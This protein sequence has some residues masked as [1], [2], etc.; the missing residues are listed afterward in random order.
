MRN[1]LATTYVLDGIKA[2]PLS[3]LPAA[4]WSPLDPDAPASADLRT[5]ARVVPILARAIDIRAKALSSLPFRVERDDGTDVTSDPLV[6]RLLEN[7]RLLLYRTE[8]GLCLHASAYWQ[9]ITNRLGKNLTPVWLAT[10]SLTAVYDLETGAPTYTRS[11]AGIGPKGVIPADHICAFLLPS[12]RVEVGAD[13][14]V[15]PAYATLAAAGVLHALDQYVLG[16]ATRGGVKITLLQVEGN[17]PQKEREKLEAWWRNVVSGIKAAFQPVTISERIKP[18]V[19]GTDPKDAAAPALTKLSR[20]DVAVGMGVPQSL[21]LSNAIAGGTADAERLNFYE[22]TVIPE[23]NLVVPVINA[24]YLAQLGLHLVADYEQLEVKQWAFQQRATAMAKLTGDAPL[25]SVDEARV[26]L[27]LPP[28][29]DVRPTEPSAPAPVPDPAQTDLKRWQ[30]KALN[31]FARKHTGSAPFESTWIDPWDALLVSQALE[32]ATTTDAIKAAFALPEPGIGLSADEQRLYD[33]LAPILSAIG[34]TTARAILMDER[35]DLSPLTQQMRAA[36]LSALLDVASEQLQAA[37]AGFGVPIDPA[38]ATAL[39]ATWS[40]GRTAVLV[41]ELTAQTQRVIDKAVAQFR[42]TPGMTRLQLEQL[43]R[44]AFSARRAETIAITSTTEAQ[45]A[46]Q[47][48]TQQYLA[49]HG[50]A[51]IRVWQTLED[52]RV[53]PVC[54]PL[55]ERPESVWQERYP[56]GPPAHPRCRCSVVLRMEDA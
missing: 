37:A 52:E 11:G 45:A 54:G 53:C 1:A 10:G 24:C 32:R 19:I 25:L 7:L 9:L 16:F 21:L 30:T 13:P 35:I 55:H 15:A 12:D 18:Q 8:I 22:F 49:S 4:A 56:D 40:A 41:P 20:E 2:V 6:Q 17:P 31:L 38:D 23:G 50:L 43:L 14:H 3:Q 47:R 26:R 5:L 34:R 33:V 27:G 28:M 42:A 29:P 46:A 51:F 39:S 36:I 48:L 44:G